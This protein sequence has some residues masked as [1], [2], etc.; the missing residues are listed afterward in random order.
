MSIFTNKKDF[1][2]KPE[3][4]DIL[5]KLEVAHKNQDELACGI[6]LTKLKQKNIKIIDTNQRMILISKLQIKLK[7]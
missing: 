2:D 7:N 5:N 6:L 4:L 3:I 1:E